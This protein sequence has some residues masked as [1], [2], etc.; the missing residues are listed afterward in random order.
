MQN[1]V[2]MEFP[3]LK[4]GLSE[5]REGAAALCYLNN[6]LSVMEDKLSLIHGLLKQTV[7]DDGFNLAINAIHFMIDKIPLQMV[8]LEAGAPI[9]RARANFGQIFSH[10]QEISYNIARADKITA[11]RFNRPLEPLFYGSLRVENPGIDP[12]LHCALECCKELIDDG[13]APDIQDVTVGKWLNQGMMP[14]LNLC[15]DERHLSAN[16]GLK[17]NMDRYR[18]ELTEFISPQASEFVFRFMKFFSEQA[19]AVNKNESSYYIM[20]AFFYAVR[21]YYA[22]TLNTAIPGIIYPSAMTDGQGLNIVLVPQAVDRFL[23][24]DMVYMQR[25]SLDRKTKTYFSAPCSELARVTNGEF[26]FK[27]VLPYLKDGRLFKY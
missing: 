8:K 10:Q 12:V 7:T 1:S 16:P 4:N 17:H 15:F 21:Y 6:H 22:N 19:W 26:G 5:M 11:G 3:A 9:F 20:N 23:R 27:N 24:L 14:V 18:Q 25:F 2:E 13:Q